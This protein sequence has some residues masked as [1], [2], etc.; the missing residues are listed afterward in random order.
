MTATAP[1]SLSPSG[2]RGFTQTTTIG[3]TARIGI[4]CEA[5]MYGRNPR[6]KQSRVREQGPEG[7]P[8]QR[9][10]DEP[11]RGLLRREEGGVQEDVD[12]Q[13]AVAP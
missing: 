13:R 1:Q 12:Q 11:D 4:V 10:E 8:D 2:S 3:A 6:W 9:A 5:T 7:E